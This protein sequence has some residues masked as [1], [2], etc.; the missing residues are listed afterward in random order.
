MKCITVRTCELAVTG[1]LMLMLSSCRS[2]QQQ[3]EDID[4]PTLEE[5][6]SAHQPDPAEIKARKTG[7]IP[8]IMIRRIDFSLESPVDEIWEMIDESSF[9]PHSREL[10]NANGFRCG[11]IAHNELASLSGSIPGNKKVTGIQMSASPHLAPALRSPPLRRPVTV[12]SSIAEPA[13]ETITLSDD[14]IQLL[15]RLANADHGRFVIDLVPHH[16]VPV[17]TMLPRHP[18]EKQLDGLILFDLAVRLEISSHESV[19]IGLNPEQT[20]QEQPDTAEEDVQKSGESGDTT[21]TNESAGPVASE[22]ETQDRIMPP[23][24]DNHLARQLLTA[25]K[26]GRPIQSLVIISADTF[27]DQP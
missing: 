9:P 14:R 8:Y 17:A 21:P 11:L 18:L 3:T 27:T 22:P 19:V 16:H 4:L 25:M 26:Y 7:P 6:R 13:D 15:A 2:P 5:I 12:I 23:R 1:C 10:W 20:H 24:T